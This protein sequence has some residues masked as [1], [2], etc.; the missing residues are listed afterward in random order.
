VIVETIKSVW[1]SPGQN[2]KGDTDSL[3]SRN[4]LT[5]E[6]NSKMIFDIGLEDLEE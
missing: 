6:C 1:L 3:L 5:T 4:I 2:L